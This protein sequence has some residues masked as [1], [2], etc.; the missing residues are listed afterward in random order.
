MKILFIIMLQMVLAVPALAGESGVD[1]SLFGD[2][3][4]RMI[5]PAAMSGRITAIDCVQEDPQIIYVGGADGGVWKS[6]N[7][8]HTFVPIFKDHAQS[9]GCLV[10]DQ[11]HLDTVWVGTG[12]CNVRNSVSIG[13]GLF[14]TGDGGRTWECVGLEES[15]RISKIIIDPDDPDIVYAAAL[16]PLWNEGGDR[17][18]Y[19]TIDRGTTWERILHVD[20]N[21]GCAD[22]EMD[23]EDPDVLYAAMWQV[24][25]KPWFFTSGGPGSGLF[26]SMDRGKTWKALHT[27]LPQGEL[28]RIAVAVAPSRSGT[29][30][31]L[32]EAGETALYRSDV[33]GESW[34]KINASDC[35]TFRPFYFSHL[36]VDP[37][38]YQKVYVAS[39]HL[40]RSNDGG[41]T[42]HSILSENVHPDIHAIWIDPRNP[43]LILIGSDGGVYQSRNQGGTFTF[44]EGL[45][46]SQFYH[47]SCDMEFPY[48]VYGGLQD[49][50]GWYGP[51]RG[52]GP[53]IQNRDWRSIGSNDGMYLVRHPNDPDILYYGW[54]GGGMARIHETSHESKEIT[55]LPAKGNE[56]YRFN[57]NAPFALSPLDPETLYTGGQYLFRSR[58]RGDSWE[59]LSPDLTT[60]DFAKLRQAESGGL[61]PES[62]PAESHCTIYTIAPSA[63]DAEVLWVGT[64]DGNVQITRDSG[65]TWENVRP[66]IPD[67]PEDAGCSCIEAGRHGPGT[68]YAVFDG[69]GLG[70][71]KAY[72]YRTCDFGMTWE[73]LCQEGIQGY[74][75]VIR[76][77]PVNP[78]LLFM[79]TEL[80]LYL[81]LDGGRHWTGLKETLPPVAVRDLAIHAREQDLVIAT[82]GLGIWIL[83][84]ITPLRDLTAEAL[85]QDAM[86]LPSRPVRL[87]LPVTVQEFPGDSIF[88]GENPHEGA[89]ITYYQKKRHVFGKLALEVLDSR[90]QVIKTLPCTKR[91]GLNRVYWDL[92]LKAP[93]RLDI[94]GVL[95]RYSFGPMV[96]EGEYTLRLT[97]GGKEY[98]GMLAVT[99]SP[100]SGHSFEERRTRHET[101][102]KVYCLQN[103]ICYWSACL[104]HGVAQADAILASNPC[105]SVGTRLVEFKSALEEF[106]GNIVQF[107]KHDFSRKLAENTAWLYKAVIQYGG[108]PGDSQLL[109]MALLEEESE[110]AGREFRHLF[111]EALDSLNILLEEAGLGRMEMLTREAYEKEVPK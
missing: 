88:I 90:G 97:R 35:V 12:E 11:K 17:G 61:S 86:M 74:G 48:R 10:I 91:P 42:I 77:D 64:D 33:M 50:A 83:D 47:V 93:R 27:G 106:H 66:R 72:V 73:S 59:I 18:V 68:A 37:L 76:E 53:G 96:E 24:R 67:V 78:D 21:T 75:H 49:N 16:G 9:I 15:E 43:D 25:R 23:P 8:G 38:D 32:V 19:R 81:S 29:V 22:L 85:D 55:P 20:E 70:D 4:A 31:A 2:M 82:H 102:M 3:K 7:G 14:R 104:S 45:P 46:L 5:G 30:Y 79:G 52:R 98:T 105:G 44:L 80:G 99:P 84:D 69:H 111:N 108:K 13:T 89:A 103:E 28:G 92:R 6:V 36:V 60:C 100:V 65:A 51:S 40:C 57:W 101:V 58:D 63:L 107:G 39:F 54:M 41:E 34:Q 56:E 1:A 87:E 109:H 110:E 71:M 94:P 62:S 95:H 26:K